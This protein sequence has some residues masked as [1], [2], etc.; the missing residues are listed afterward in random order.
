MNAEE[1]AEEVEG[2]DPYVC[3]VKK[4]SEGKCVFLSGETCTVYSVRP[5]VCRFYPFELK[6]A[7]N[8]RY[9]FSY[10]DECPSIGKGPC[11]RKSHFRKLFAELERT[12][13]EAWSEKELDSAHK[14][15]F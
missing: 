10:T 4:T 14:T 3:R 15:H 5:L 2:H 6:P 8:K 7:G 12:L 11:L 9:V 1:F 13:K